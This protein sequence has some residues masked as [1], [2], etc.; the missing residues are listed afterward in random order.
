MITKYREGFGPY[1]VIGVSSIKMNGNEIISGMGVKGGIKYNPTPQNFTPG[2]FTSIA[3]VLAPF[4]MTIEATWCIYEEEQVYRT[5]IQMPSYN[6]LNKIIAES[7][8]SAKIKMNRINDFK[9]LKKI[10][11]GILFDMPP[12]VKVFV[13]P[14]EMDTPG[15]PIKYYLIAQETGDRVSINMDEYAYSIREICSEGL[16]SDKVCDKYKPY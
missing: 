1:G 10:G 7:N 2:W 8:K 12:Q 9:E 13:F 15:L 3:S 14:A 16:L 11:L 4:P 6:E 5:F